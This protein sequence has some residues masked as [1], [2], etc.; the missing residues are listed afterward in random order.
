MLKE[1]IF[2]SHSAEGSGYP[3]HARELLRALYRLGKIKIKHFPIRYGGESVRKDSEMNFILAETQRVSV[4]SNAP[5]LFLCVP[6]QINF[7]IRGR[8]ASYTTWE[9]DRICPYWVNIANVI[10]FTIVT[11]SFLKEVWISS[12]VNPNKMEIAEEGVNTDVFYPDLEPLCLEENGVEV[13]KKYKNRFLAVMEYTNRKNLFGLLD[14]F[15]KAFDGD[16]ETCLL[17]KISH[18]EQVEPL[19]SEIDTKAANILLYCQML[20]DKAM[21]QFMAIGT[22]YFSMSHGEG[23][24]LNCINMGG[25]KRTV[26]VPNHSAY[27]TY[28]DDDKAFLIRA[29]RK[30]D[31]IQNPPLDTL[32]NGSQWWC[33]DIDDAVDKLRESIKTDNAEKKEK[34]Y[35]A[36]QEK[37][38]WKNSAEKVLEILNR[39]WG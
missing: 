1:L 22:H 12:G 5:I 2:V 21:S 17:L 13:I 35:K 38:T 24:D 34:F 11:N 28:L 37:Y 23:C 32:F 27:S 30:E 16:E 29:D 9:A 3:T 31:A 25:M 39:R 6:N 14:A 26:I 7:K 4:S 10:D 20:S 18:W 36:I 33:P 19:L 8:L 15:I